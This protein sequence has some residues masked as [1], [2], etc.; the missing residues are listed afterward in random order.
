MTGARL[1][2]LQELNL[3][4]KFKWNLKAERYIVKLRL[5]GVR[6]A[7]SCQHDANERHPSQKNDFQIQYIHWTCT[8]YVTYS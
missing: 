2:V 3:N 4:S 8:L 7:P 1:H 5:I 6:V